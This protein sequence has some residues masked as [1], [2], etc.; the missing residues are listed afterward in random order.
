M[1]KKTAAASVRSDAA[2]CLSA[3]LIVGLRTI[4]TGFNRKRGVKEDKESDKKRK[5]VKM[6]SHPGR[7]K[8]IGLGLELNMCSVSF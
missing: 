4:T 7:S 5:K 2:A 6:G 1:M 8:R 3:T